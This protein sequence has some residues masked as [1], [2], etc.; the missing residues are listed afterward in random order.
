MRQIP[1]QRDE[2]IL[3]LYLYMQNERARNIKTEPAIAELSQLLRK[4]AEFLALPHDDT[5]RS[6]NSIYLKLQNLKRLDPTYEGIGLKAGNQMEEE[7]WNQF[8]GDVQYLKD[9]SESIIA[10]IS[11][12]I[13]DDKIRV[14]D[15]EEDDF[16]EG[17]VLY[18][19]HRYWER[20]SK[21]IT[22][23]KNKAL[24]SDKFYCE[25]CGFSFPKPM[26][27]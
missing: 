13:K 4:R 22:Q 21:L 5:F 24:L 18:R 6:I 23:A 16:P 27:N 26:E 15:P 14:A 25:I 17:N 19:I 9:I 2:L 10:T 1:W 3:A 8:A 20:N 11:Q 7:I 12:Q